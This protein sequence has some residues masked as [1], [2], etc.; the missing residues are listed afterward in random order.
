MKAKAQREQRECDLARGFTNVSD[1]Q[2]LFAAGRKRPAESAFSIPSKVQ[3]PVNQRDART[4]TD[5]PGEPIR[6]VRNFAKYVDFDFSKMTDTKGGFLTAEDDPHNRAMR[7]GQLSLK[8]WERQQELK[9]GKDSES[10]K[11]RI[12]SEAQA[13]RECRSLDTD[14]KWAKA[15]HVGICRACKDKYPEKYSLLTKT[16]VKEDYL[17]TD[18]T[19]LPSFVKC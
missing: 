11:A 14:E 3:V 2:P 17:L 7:S 16:E 1:Q 5:R 8:E 18:R 19:Q 13:C 4:P 9:M 15:F 6:P 12:S 10:V